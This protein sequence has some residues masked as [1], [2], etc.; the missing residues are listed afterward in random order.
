M[1]IGTT[2]A[3]AAAPTNRAAAPRATPDYEAFLQLMIA[4]M[5]HQDP[6]DPMDPSQQMAQLASFSQVEQAMQTNAKL[7][8]LLA[9][10]A[11]AQADGVIGRTVTS[12]DGSVS[13]E[14]TAL[15]LVPGGAVAVLADG[16]QVPLVPGVTIA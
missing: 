9:T 14:A 5:R 3:A 8:A 12:D 4:Q 16:R 13:G 10:A 7:D 15:S 6:T 1:E 11:L 2:A